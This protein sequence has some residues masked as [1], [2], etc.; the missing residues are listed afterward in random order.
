MIHRRSFARAALAGAVLVFALAPS[1]ATAERLEFSR[2]GARAGLSVDPEQ[3]VVGVY[4]GFG[5]LARNLSV[6]PS[7]DLGLGDNLT[8]LVL[9]GDLQFSFRD[10]DWSGVPYVGGGIALSYFNFD[11]GGDDTGIGLNAYAGIERS[12]ADYTSGHLEARLGFDDVP[13]F[14][15]IAG[16]GFY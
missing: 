11:G 6:R 14:K 3:L 16:F 8:T 2:Y 13:E 9:N 15:L 10:T 7:A 12:L 4:A 5:E 1:P